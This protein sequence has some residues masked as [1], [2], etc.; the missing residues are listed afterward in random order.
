MIGPPPVGQP[1]GE[2]KPFWSSKHAKFEHV[3]MRAPNKS[4]SLLGSRVRAVFAC[5]IFLS[6]KIYVQIC[7]ERPCRFGAILLAKFGGRQSRNPTWT[8]FYCAMPPPG[9]TCIEYNPLWKTGC[10]Y[11]GFGCMAPRRAPWPR[12]LRSDS[13]PNQIGGPM[14]WKRPKTRNECSLVGPL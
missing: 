9:P 14:F 8:K 12:C 13:G 6:L 11:D 10:P 5:G 3:L 7:Y 1:T 2:G 4:L